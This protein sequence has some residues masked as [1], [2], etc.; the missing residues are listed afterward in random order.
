[1]SMD[2]NET[3]VLG[4]GYIRLSLNESAVCLLPDLWRLCL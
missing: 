2:G 3:W 1:M 4:G